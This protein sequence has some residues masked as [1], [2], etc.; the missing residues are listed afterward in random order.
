MVMDITT[1]Q[2]YA[3][4]L[5]VFLL[6]L[7]LAL[8]SYLYGADTATSSLTDGSGHPVRWSL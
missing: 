8:S 6:L 1:L 7:A 4:P 5:L 3:Q 2:E